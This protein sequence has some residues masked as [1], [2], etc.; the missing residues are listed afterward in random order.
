MDT[1]AQTKATT[2][3]LKTPGLQSGEMKVTFTYKH[4]L[5]VFFKLI[6]PYGHINIK[7]IFRLHQDVAKQG[8]PMWNRFMR[9]LSSGLIW[10]ASN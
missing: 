4:L 3:W 9:I 2:G 6:E 5:Q 7:C 10:Q 1:E 8:Q